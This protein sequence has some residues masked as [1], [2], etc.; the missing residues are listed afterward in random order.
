MNLSALCKTSGT[1]LLLS[2]VVLSQQW[3]NISP[4]LGVNCNINSS[5]ISA[6]EGWASSMYFAHADT[7]FH[8]ANGGSSWDN[9]YVTDE[10][11]TILF[12]QM[13]DSLTGWITTSLI[14]DVDRMYKTTDGGYNWSD[15][16]DETMMYHLGPIQASNPFYFVN[17]N[18]GFTGNYNMV[19]RTTDGGLS[20]H[21]TSMPIVLDPN[22]PVE[23]DFYINNLYFINEQYGWAVCNIPFDAGM[24]LYTVDYGESWEI[25]LEP[26]TPNLY[27]VHFIDPEFGMVGGWS[28]LGT[29]Y[30]TNNNFE[31][32]MYTQ[33][34]PDVSTVFV[35]DY[36]NL[37][38]T[39]D[40]NG[41][42]GVFRS[43]NGGYSFELM[44]D[45]SININYLKIAIIGNV[46]Y[47][48]GSGN[49]FIKYTEY[50]YL[51]GDLNEDQLIDILDIV[52]VI[53]IILN[54]I[55]PTQY[56]V[57]VGDL[58]QDQDI[59]ILDIVIIVNIIIGE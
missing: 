45:T 19:Y 29:V 50:D 9:R 59:T 51:Y 22:W 30:I 56:Q 58:D 16:T 42:T 14:P 25:G 7:I 49:N 57:I 23:L 4:F 39:A 54:E 40:S 27:S 37:W 41:N 53:G 6:N 18:I 43:S 52:I 44:Y 3:S 46:G 5:F 20:W 36:E 2:T 12:I 35:Q 17:H 31:D 15:I 34:Y 13:V 10:S 33:N 21:P 32:V 55:E 48:W 47:F 24:S 8:T 1:V 26:Y 38:L 11:E 28:T